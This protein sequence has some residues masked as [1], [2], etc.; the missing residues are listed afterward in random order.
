MGHAYTPPETCPV[1]GDDVPR[2]ALACPG[3]GADERSGWNEDAARYDG[4]DLPDAAYADED[5]ERTA[6]RTH[7]GGLGLAILIGVLVL[8]TM[9]FLFR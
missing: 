1:C 2:G 9:A 6:R 8:L 5:T 7:V 3:C 4:L